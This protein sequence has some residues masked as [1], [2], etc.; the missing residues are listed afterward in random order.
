MVD[1]ILSP[2]YVGDSSSSK[3]KVI[4][5]EEHKSM[6][7]LPIT[8]NSYGHGSYHGPMFY[9][10]P[11]GRVL[12]IKRTA[13]KIFAASL[14]DFSKYGDFSPQI[15]DVYRFKEW[16]ATGE[17]DTPSKHNVIPKNPNFAVIQS[18]ILGVYF[19]SEHDTP[20]N[21]RTSHDIVNAFDPNRLGFA[22]SKI[23]NLEQTL[24]SMNPGNEHYSEAAEWIDFLA[25]K[26]FSIDKS[27]HRGIIGLGVEEGD[28]LAAY[29][30]AGYLVRESNFHNKAKRLIS[31][32]G[33]TESEAVK[34][35]QRSVLLHESGH[36]VGIESEKLQ[37][38]L[39]AEFYST[40]AQK[41]KGT[42]WERIY[43][44]LAQEGMGYAKE[45]SLANKILDIISEDTSDRAIFNKYKNKFLI[46]AIRQGETDV[47][48]YISRRMEETFGSLKGEPSYKSSKTN[49]KSNNK[50][51][52]NKKSL[53]E[54]A[55]D[56][57]KILIAVDEE[58]IVPT[59]EGRRVYGEGASM[60]K[61]LILGKSKQY[62]DADEKTYERKIDKSKYRSMKDAEASMKEG[63][64]TRA[65]K[66]AIESSDKAEKEAPQEAEANAETAEASSE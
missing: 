21:L 61:E 5:P 31:K 17:D 8:E 27:P 46:E 56:A 52:S 13:N 59:Y 32:Y 28:F 18:P 22:Y 66:R 55:S 43:K 30:P 36:V 53:E 7:T 64:E 26:G 11:D 38:L 62:K 57:D 34:A 29:Y 49:S 40:M 58:G 6:Q 24:R 9:Q 33:L 16:K 23:A 37:G 2:H 25:K 10:M 35:M 3:P 48:A 12:P 63:N 20:V 15:D 42:K 1:K 39:Q 14:N 51:A 4:K 60:P 47:E 65:E 44:A 19:P 54:I 41:Y 50:Q 45:H